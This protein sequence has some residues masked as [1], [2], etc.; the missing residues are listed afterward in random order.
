MQSR[1]TSTK[2]HNKVGREAGKEQEKI[3]Y[4]SLSAMRNLL[5]KTGD[6]D[7]FFINLEGKKHDINR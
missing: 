1:R 2:T 3:L 6:A 7:N 4:L 5:W